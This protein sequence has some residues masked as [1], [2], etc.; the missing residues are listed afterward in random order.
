MSAAPR[1]VPLGRVI[2]AEEAGIY[3]DAAG[4]L[5]AAREAAGAIRARAE[6]EA[7]AERARRIESAEREAHEAAAR[8]LAGHAAATARHARALEREV[9]LAIAEGVAKVVRGLDLADRVARAAREA[10]SRLAGSGA[11]TLRVAPGL[12]AALR[13]ALPREVTVAED[14]GLRG[15]ECLLDTPAGSVVATPEAQLAALRDALVSA[16]EARA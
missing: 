1:L 7:A 14:P 8:L 16:A 5:A 13:E 3:A 15:D 4:A 2:R 9:A 6:S 11:V 10:S 12:A